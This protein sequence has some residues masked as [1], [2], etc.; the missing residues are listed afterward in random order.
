M[1]VDNKN[2]GILLPAIN[3]ALAL[4]G[5]GLTACFLGRPLAGL[6]RTAVL[7]FF[8]TGGSYVY[9]GL[10]CHIP[11]Y[12]SIGRRLGTVFSAI[13]F[14]AYASLQIY[15]LK[16]APGVHGTFVFL[17]LPVFFW[18]YSISAVFLLLVTRRRMV[19]MQ[20]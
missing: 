6:D 19:G 7:V 15:Y 1:K 14:I 17:L 2:L 3:W 5:I 20:A 11:R 4:C 18:V 10:G 9:L 16:I 13:H 8:W 12:G